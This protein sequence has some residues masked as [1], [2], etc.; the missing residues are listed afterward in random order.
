MRYLLLRVLTAALGLSC[1]SFAQSV[2]TQAS[3]AW[4]N[5]RTPGQAPDAA[6]AKTLPLIS[7]KG[8][9]FVDAQGTPVLF[10]GV[11]IGDPTKLKGQD[12]WKRELFV[13]LQQMGVHVVRIPVHPIAWRSLGARDYLAL[14]DQAVAWCTELGMYIDLDWHSIGNLETG[15]FQDPMYDT[16]KQET[17]NFW[18]TAAAHYAG[19]NTVAFFELFN[20]PSTGSDRWGPVRWTEWKR[21]NEDL[22]QMIRA[23]DPQVIPLVAGFDWAYDLTPLHTDPIDAEGIGYVTHPYPMKRTK[24]WEPKWEE[25]FGFAARKYPIIATEIGYSAPAPGQR[26]NPFA[27]ASYGPAIVNYLEGRGISWIA[28]CFDPQ[29]GPTLISSWDGYPLTAAGD[30]FQHAMQQPSTPAG[31]SAT[32]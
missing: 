14:V 24:P 2:P 22:I 18:R 7:V 21:T 27:D 3:S 30:F 31:T 28:W 17:F 26:P 13:R 16:S 25:D 12:Q 19:H 23:A 10:R 6:G 8:N 9:R 20:E 11:S 29:W 4:W 15:V 32:Q 5:A 1:V